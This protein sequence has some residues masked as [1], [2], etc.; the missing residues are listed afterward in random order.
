[1]LSLGNTSIRSDNPMPGQ[2]FGAL[3]QRPSDGTSLA[4]IPQKQSYMTVRGYH[5]V[6]Y[7]AHHF[8][9]LGKV[10]VHDGYSLGRKGFAG[11]DKLFS[12]L[13]IVVWFS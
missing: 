1:M 6:G 4:G 5:A 2:L 7:A 10:R 11:N 12:I 8:V 13:L 3:A 9:D